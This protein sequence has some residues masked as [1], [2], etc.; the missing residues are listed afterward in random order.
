MARPVPMPPPGFEDLSSEER[1]SYVQSLWD[2]ISSDESKIPVPN[3]HRSE[4][5]RRLRKREGTEV[6]SRNWND[7]RSELR[8]NLKSDLGD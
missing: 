3:W 8:Q 1:V 5:K 7:V 2:L 6:D 4:I